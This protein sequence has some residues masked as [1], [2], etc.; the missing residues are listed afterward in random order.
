MSLKGKVVLITGGGRDIGKACALDIAKQGATVVVTYLSSSNSANQLVEEISE[1]G[2]KAIAIKADLTR[3]ENVDNVVNTVIDEFG[4][5]DSLIHVSG[6]LIGRVQISEMSDE[7]WDNVLNVNLK[8]LFMTT[9]ACIP[10]MKSGSTI[11]TFA[12]QAGRDGGGPGAV[13]Y[14]TAK[15]AVMTFTRG[16][17]KELGPDIR[18]N[19]VC[20][21][22]IDTDFHNNFTQDAVRKNVAGATCIKREGQPAEV[23]KLVTFLVSED[24]SYMTGNCIDING[25]LLFS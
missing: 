6:G 24:A 7:H 13:A 11:V 5:L 1:L 17:A 2:Q 10:H 15:G 19:S 21:G 3:Q 12:S 18:V 25:G 4:Q 16:L 22:M 20:P 14:A 9:K 8:S 23:A